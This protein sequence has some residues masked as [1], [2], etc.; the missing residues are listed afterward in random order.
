MVEDSNGSLG[1]WTFWLGLTF[2][3]G[4]IGNMDLLAR[5]N[6]LAGVSSGNMDLLASRHSVDLLCLKVKWMIY[7][8]RSNG[9]S[10]PNQEP[11]IFQGSVDIRF[12]ATTGSPLADH[13]KRNV[14]GV[15]RARGRGLERLQLGTV[16]IKART[17]SWR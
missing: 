14:A 6:L 9:A 11:P 2:W 7:A 10:D 1:I 16:R 3:L 13:G 5:V 17:N 12:C 8:V 4:F 15:R